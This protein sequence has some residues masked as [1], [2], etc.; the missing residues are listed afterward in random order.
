MRMSFLV[1]QNFHVFLHGSPAIKD[2]GLNVG[3]VLAETGVFVLD[4]EG[5]LSSMAHDYHG[6]FSSNR[7]DRL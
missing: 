5:Q 7:L 4:L 3:N 2:S 1:L 6:R